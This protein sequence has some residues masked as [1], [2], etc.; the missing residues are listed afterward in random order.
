MQHCHYRIQFAEPNRIPEL[1]RLWSDIFGDSDDYTALFFSRVYAPGRALIATVDEQVAAMLF[2]PARRMALQGKPVRVGYVCGAATRPEYRGRGIMA[3]MLAAARRRHWRGFN[4]GVRIPVRLLCKIR[5]PGIL[6]SGYARAARMRYANGRR[7]RTA[8]AA[9][10]S[11]PDP[12]C[13]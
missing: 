7:T 3:A 1:R 10:C 11:G 5:L 13:L 8:Y 4:S 9:G 2:F 6:L 12:A